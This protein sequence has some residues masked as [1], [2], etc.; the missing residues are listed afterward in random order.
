MSLARVLS[1]DPAPGKKSTIFDGRQF[2]NCKPEEL[3][4]YLGRIQPGTLIC[5]DAPLTGPR[6]PEHAG[7]HGDFTQRP[8]DS[9]FVRGATRFKAP[10]G[11]SVLPYG[12]CPHWTITRSLLGLPRVG[13][14]DR[15]YDE[16]PFRLLPQAGDSRDLRPA[17][18][19]IHPAVAIWLWCR[20][21]ERADWRYKKSDALRAELLDMICERTGFPFDDD[22]RK[23]MI[24][25]DDN[26]DAA[27]GYILG[28]L[29][30]AE[31]GRVVILGT[32]ETGAMLLPQVDHL[33]EAW[34]QDRNRS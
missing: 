17:V 22:L 28:K 12:G 25:D 16:L 2:R 19:E 30:I 24:H 14:Y 10:K 9:F 32:R 26:L 4:N 8:I 13:P 18:V 34:E 7:K 23:R 27:V 1:I 31:S 6:D 15:G 3:R 21:P 5:W 29:Y 20:N 11:I 33:V